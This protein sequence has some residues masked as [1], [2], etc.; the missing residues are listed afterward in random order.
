MGLDFLV[1][2]QNAFILNTSSPRWLMV[3]E[4]PGPNQIY[5]LQQ[6]LK[7]FVQK[8]KTGV[9]FTAKGGFTFTIDLWWLNTPHFSVFTCKRNSKTMNA[10]FS[11]SPLY[12]TLYR[13]VT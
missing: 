9:V 5:D 12:I 7:N 3:V 6:N 4:L 11:T 13:S 8:K 1:K 10:F 2:M